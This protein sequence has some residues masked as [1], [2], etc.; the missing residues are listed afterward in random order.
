MNDIYLG[1]TPVRRLPMV[2]GIHRITLKKDDFFTYAENVKVFGPTD[3]KLKLAP[4]TGI[5]CLAFNLPPEKIYLDGQS[6]PGGWDTLDLPVGPHDIFAYRSGF[7]FLRSRVILTK[8]KTNTERLGFAGNPLGSSFSLASE[9]SG[10][11]VLVQGLSLGRTP[12]TFYGLA[13]NEVIDLSLRLNGFIEENLSLTLEKKEKRSLSIRLK[14]IREG[15]LVL[16]GTP[17]GI[18]LIL[19]KIS[20]D[21]REIVKSVDLK[22]KP[23]FVLL[24]GNYFLELRSPDTFP[25]D[26]SF[27]ISND[28]PF[29]VRPKLK[30]RFTF[31]KV[32]ELRDAAQTPFQ[33]IS[34]LKILGGQIW[35]VDE[36]ASS[37]VRLGENLTTVSRKKIP[38]LRAVGGAGSEPLVSGSEGFRTL[39]GGAVPA[40]KGFSTTFADFEQTE[41]R[42]VFLNENRTKIFIAGQDGLGPKEIGAEL[43]ATASHPFKPFRLS[44]MVV[45]GDALYFA[46]KANGGI[47]C[48]FLTST[49]KAP[50]FKR[51][52]AAPTGL[53]LIDD[54]L[55]SPTDGETQAEIWDENLNSLGTI[56]LGEISGKSGTA[57]VSG[58]RLYLVL[59]QNRIA[60]FRK[61]ITGSA[62]STS[63]D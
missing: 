24:P 58:D 40:M 63:S 7:P 11:D 49:N 33:S 27:S 29:V 50:F 9:P 4:H 39:D 10:A 26:L 12:F 60:V 13:P 38:G 36:G 5:L 41:G 53:V 42:F 45:K 20:K 3:L 28:E 59:D 54:F 56:P 6:L 37:L 17:A 32:R 30:R 1:K 14:K 34:S 57:A 16:E 44:Q 43:F 18:H 51:A 55:L 47:G 22:E 15:N 62:G 52:T 2:P 35:V 8:D 19:T 48:V 31:E 25:F 46:D 61:K 23:A 21:K